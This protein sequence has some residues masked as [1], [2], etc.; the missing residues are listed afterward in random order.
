MFD[1]LALQDPS[2]IPY[3]FPIRLSPPAHDARAITPD[4]SALFLSSQSPF[5]S[6]SLL[7]LPRKQ[8]VEAPQKR[9]LLIST[10]QDALSLSFDPH[11]D[12][13]KG[14][15]HFTETL[16]RLKVGRDQLFPNTEDWNTSYNWALAVDGDDSTCW[17]TR[18]PPRVSDHFGLHWTTPRTVDQVRLLGSQD[19]MHVLSMDDEDLK[20]NSWAL[21]LLLPES[22]EWQP[23][24]FELNSHGIEEDRID[25]KLKLKEPILASKLRF[26]STDAKTAPLVLCELSVT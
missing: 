14:L 3:P 15:G 19:L 7:V 25:V 22:E 20:D 13:A 24:A 9:P 12:L 18:K 10:A 5:P 23:A 26:I 21:Q 8:Q 1:N 16:D 17:T 4:G 6:P 2:Y 11:V